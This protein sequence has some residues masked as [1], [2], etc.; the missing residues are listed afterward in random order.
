MS[1][2][3]HFPQPAFTGREIETLKGELSHLALGSSL[4]QGSRVIGEHDCMSPQ[5]EIRKSCVIV[6]FLCYVHRIDKLSSHLSP[7]IF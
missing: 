3:I 5:H 2:L 1:S 4:A 6:V 7:L